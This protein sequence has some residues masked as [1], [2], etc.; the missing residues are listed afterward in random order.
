M[1]HGRNEMFY[2]TEVA[3][4]PCYAHVTGYYGEKG[5]GSKLAASDWEFYGWS[6][7]EFELRSRKDESVRA[8]WLE[9]RM[10]E[11][12]RKSIKSMLES[13]MEKSRLEDEEDAKIP[14]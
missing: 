13:E 7:I 12:E 14:Y 2:E 8:T 4:V 9:K 10:T 6:E 1:R 11:K 5:T 3:G